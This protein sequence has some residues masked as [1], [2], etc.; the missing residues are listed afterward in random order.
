MPIYTQFSLRI[1]LYFQVAKTE[2]HSKDFGLKGVL[3]LPLHVFVRKWRKRDHYSIKL[4][5]AIIVRK[6]SDRLV[7]QLVGL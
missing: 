6:H 4:D 1:C 7:G 3:K 5:L 2:Y